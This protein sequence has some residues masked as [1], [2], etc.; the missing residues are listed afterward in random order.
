MG[1]RVFDCTLIQM[2]QPGQVH[3]VYYCS[4]AGSAVQ[5][6]CSPS[7]RARVHGLP[8]CLLQRGSRAFKPE[9]ASLGKAR[10]VLSGS[11]VSV[12]HL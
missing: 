6:W 11:V 10:V 4:L 12:W 7:A 9:K 1:W 3:V 2:D 8:V 5:Y